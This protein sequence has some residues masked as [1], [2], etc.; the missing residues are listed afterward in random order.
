MTSN[1]HGSEQPSDVPTFS[2]HSLDFQDDS[3]S[4]CQAGPLA[5]KITK[6]YARVGWA[7]GGTLEE[8]IGE[9]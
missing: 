9:E 5:V 1:L 4:S 6:K 7:C 2:C 8:E 3:V